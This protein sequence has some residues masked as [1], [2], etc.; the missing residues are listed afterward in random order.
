M[1]GNKPIDLLELAKAAGLAEASARAQ[2]SRNESIQLVSFVPNREP[3]RNLPVGHHPV[4]N[5]VVFPD[6]K[7]DGAVIKPGE[8]YFCD[9]VEYHPAVGPSVYYANPIRR[10]DPSFLFDIHPNQVDQVISAVMRSS[11]AQVLQQARAKIQSEVE[12]ATKVELS[13]LKSE[14]DSLRAENGSLKAKLSKT[15]E[16]RRQPEV[17]MLPVTTQTSVDAA[18]APNHP[19]P[20]GN[21]AP[22]ASGHVLRQS[23][24]QLSSPLLEDG[25]YFVHVSPDR[26]RLFIHSHPEGN[27]AAKGTTLSVPGL[28]VLRP[29]DGKESLDALVDRRVGGLIVDLLGL[30][31]PD[32]A[33]LQVMPLTCGSLRN[34]QP[35]RP[36]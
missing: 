11:Q 19:T 35:Q 3:G 23:A 18:P 31:T 6:M 22:L 29:F 1:N 27:L 8:T 24:N 21:A 2:Q 16:T 36:V 14:L 4:T 32:P 5:R 30:P 13:G 17:Q 25:R 10:V 7:R 15:P 9:L 20:P 33:P 28:S 34:P 12:E 26:K